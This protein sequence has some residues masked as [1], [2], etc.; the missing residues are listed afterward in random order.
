MKAS[1][2]CLWRQQYGLKHKNLDLDTWCMAI[3]NLVENIEVNVDNLELNANIRVEDVQAGNLE[4]MNSPRIPVA[5][6]VMTRQLR[7]EE[8][9]AEKDAKKK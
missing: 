5:S 1:Q 8:A 7:Q 9:S 6:V 2:F 3:Y 4:I